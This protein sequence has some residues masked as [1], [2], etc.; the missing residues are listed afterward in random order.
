VL[1]LLV[2]VV[3][4]GSVYVVLFLLCLSGS[5]SDHGSIT[6]SARSISLTISILVG[7]DATGHPNISSTGCSF[8][9]GHLSVK[10]HGGARFVVAITWVC[11]ENST[12]K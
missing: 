7:A 6:A 11:W 4:R 9:V 12:G 1:L 3:C 2:V 5:V 8:D 10:I